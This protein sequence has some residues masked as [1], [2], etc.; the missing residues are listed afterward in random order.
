MA[1]SIEELAALIEIDPATLKATVDRYNELCAAGK[2]ED[3]GKSATKMIPLTG[4]TYAAIK[5]NPAVTVTYGGLVTDTASRVLNAEG[6]PIS[7]LYAAGE[8]AFS[9]LFG[10]EYPC[11][12]MAIGSAIY[13]GRIAGQEAVK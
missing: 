1:N 7:G 5:L 11:C 12:G 6:S 3:F 2:D 4:P 8:V 9:G 13:Y 10:T